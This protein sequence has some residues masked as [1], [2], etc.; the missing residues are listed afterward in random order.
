MIVL[1]HCHCDHIYYLAELVEM[2]K[3]KVAC[4]WRDKNA[5]ETLGE[6][7]ISWLCGKELK[8]VRVDLALKEGDI[9]DLGNMKLEVLEVPGHT[10]GSIALFDK[11]HGILFSGDT[12]F[13]DSIGRW[14]LPGG[15][16]EELEK[17]VAR[18]SALKARL[19]PGH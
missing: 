15:N 12:L 3:C 11:E 17:S 16:K 9:L 8:P 6:E 4:G 1:T 14:D 5:I 7:T 13:E 18:L 10:P 19:F 2:H